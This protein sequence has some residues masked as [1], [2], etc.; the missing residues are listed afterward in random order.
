MRSGRGVGGGGVSRR[1]VDLELP[2]LETEDAGP[3]TAH[4]FEGVGGDEH[5]RAELVQAG[6]ELHDLERKI[7]IEVPRGLV[8][9]ED[10]RTGDDRPCDADALLLTAR[11][12]ERTGRFFPEKTH[13]VEGRTHPS[14]DLPLAVALDDERERH[15]VEDRAVREEAVVLEDDPDPLAVVGEHVARPGTEEPPFDVQPPAGGSLEADEESQ[16]TTLARPRGSGE[17]DHLPALDRE[18]E[19]AQRLL[20]RR[21][22]ERD[23]LGVDRGDDGRGRTARLAPVRTGADASRQCGLCLVVEGHVQTV[24]VGL[25]FASPLPMGGDPRP[26]GS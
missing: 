23:V 10:R 2:G 15:V 20:P 5:G 4:D 7:R 12:G 11:E 22:A 13:L 26:W 17:E 6:E 18:V 9:K 19:I 16:E 1:A 25:R 24:R 21:I 3:E 8:G 14:A